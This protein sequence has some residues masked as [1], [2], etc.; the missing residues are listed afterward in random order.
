VFCGL[1]AS[2]GFCAWVAVEEASSAAAIV[3][4]SRVMI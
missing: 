1:T 2:L 3:I 4:E